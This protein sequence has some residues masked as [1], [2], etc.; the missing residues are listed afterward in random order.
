MCICINCNYVKKCSIYRL[1]E[2]HH[3]QFDINSQK[4]EKLF[5]PYSFVININ[6]LSKSESRLDWDVVECVS[7]IEAPGKWLHK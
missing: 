7:F 6:I 3:Q 2:K 5:I 4:I 1:I